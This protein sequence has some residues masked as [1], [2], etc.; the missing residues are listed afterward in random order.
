MVFNFFESK[1]ELA[2][3][4]RHVESLIP[5]PSEVHGPAFIESECV[6]NKY[7]MEIL[8]LLFIWVLKSK[9]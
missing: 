1:Y 9:F 2:R 3:L 8:L 6:G 5:L 4:L 7:S